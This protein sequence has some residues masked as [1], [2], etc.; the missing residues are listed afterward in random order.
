MALGVAAA[1][2]APVLRPEVAEAVPH[3]STAST[4]GLVVADGALYE[5]TGGRGRSTVRRVDLRTGR[6]LDV[7]SLGAEHFGEGLAV[8]GDRLV[9]LTWTAGLAIV[10]DRATLAPLD[11]LRYHPEGWG[12]AAD[13]PHLVFSDGSDTLWWLDPATFQ[14]VRC[15]QVHDGGQRVRGLNELEVVGGLV[16]AN[17]RYSGRIAAIDAESGAVAYWLDLTALS[18]EHLYASRGEMNGIAF[19]PTTGRLLV[20]GKNWPAVYAL[21]G[22]GAPD[23]VA[24][25]R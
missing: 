17:V 15:V 13:G 21:T 6:V 8:V 9:Q 7:R 25:E 24:G 14:P 18:D 5:S 10:Y 11:T 19:D 22:F 16:F 12:L 2:P 3:D 20:T 1:Q 23:A 4:Q